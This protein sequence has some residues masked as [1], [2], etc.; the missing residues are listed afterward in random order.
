MDVAG[1]LRRTWW[2][3]VALGAVGVL[4]G[5]VLPVSNVPGDSTVPASLAW[6]ARTLVGTAPGGGGNQVAGDV[7]AAQIQ[8]YGSGLVVET[9]AAKAAG[10]DVPPSRYPA[11]FSAV[12]GPGGAST[13]ASGATSTVVLTTRGRTRAEATSLGN[14]Y[15]DQ[16]GKYLTFLATTSAIAKG[17]SGT[18]VAGHTGYQ[19]LETASATRSVS[20]PSGGSAG[21]DGYGA[22]SVWSSGCSSGWCL[23]SL[24]TRHGDGTIEHWP[25]SPGPGPPLASRWSSRSRRSCHR[26]RTT[27]VLPRWWTS[28]ATPTRWGPRPTGCCGCPC[29]SSRYRYL[30]GRVR[31]PRNG[32][33]RPERVEGG[34]STNGTS[35]DGGERDQAEPIRRRLVGEIATEPDVRARGV[36]GTDR[37][38]RAP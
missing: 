18:V 9:A 7:T 5:V 12:I 10:L 11:Y 22:P 30:L 32:A 27:V 33:D 24:S 23:R 16:L 1:A 28:C 36:V 13:S 34:S 14:A 25:T 21:P 31:Q 4:V 15:A 17:G 8:F 3:V 2:L 6:Q 35:P 29:C 19:V 26:H 20:A 37:T 38:G